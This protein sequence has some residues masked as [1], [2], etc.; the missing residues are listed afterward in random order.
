L[1]THKIK[2]LKLNK[3]KLLVNQ[4][5]CGKANVSWPQ[6]VKR[7]VVRKFVCSK[8]TVKYAQSVILVLDSSP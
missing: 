7:R 2:I 8:G 4:R 3:G 5:G 6:W 1:N